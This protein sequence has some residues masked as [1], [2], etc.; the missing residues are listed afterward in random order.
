MVFFPHSVVDKSK[1]IEGSGVPFL[2]LDRVD[3]LT[4]A[5]EFLNLQL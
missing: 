3:G 1:G 5:L 2:I 4:C